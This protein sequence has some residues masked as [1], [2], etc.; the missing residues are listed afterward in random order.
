[1][2]CWRANP[3]TRITSKVEAVGD[4]VRASS[5][6]QD[7]PAKAGA[8]QRQLTCRTTKPS[9]TTRLTGSGFSQPATLGNLI[10]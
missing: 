1:M 3:E 2:A 6:Q 8:R 10:A 5:G 9:A 7:L 4:D